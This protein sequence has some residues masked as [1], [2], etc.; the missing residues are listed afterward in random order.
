MVKSKI[1]KIMN[2]NIKKI[3][4]IFQA[5]IDGDT[6]KNSHQKCDNVSNTLILYKS[7]SNRRFGGFTSECWNS[8]GDNIIDKN[9]F[10]FSLDKKKIYSPKKDK[11]FKISGKD[12]DGPSFIYDDFY[13]IR[14]QE[15]SLKSRS[16]RTEGKKDIFGDDKYPLSEDNA[17]QGVY[18]K[19]YEVL[20]IIKFIVRV[21][22]DIL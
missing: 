7:Y 21:F 3:Y 14:L 6:P 5:T 17:F 22:L 4:K 10:L 18:A 13:L 16:L 12:I 15:D 1:E 8:R 11:Y 20:E 19:E 9:C 2:K